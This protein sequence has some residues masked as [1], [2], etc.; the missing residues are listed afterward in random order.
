MEKQ[1]G[2]KKIN[3]EYCP[4]FFERKNKIN[5]NNIFLQLSNQRE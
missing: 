1:S 3:P 2:S 4:Y 5:I